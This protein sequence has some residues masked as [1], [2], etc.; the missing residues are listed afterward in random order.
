[1]SERRNE[2]KIEQVRKKKKIRE[3][4]FVEPLTGGFI[5]NTGGIENAEDALE[6]SPFQ[7]EKKGKKG[8]Y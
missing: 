3:Y 6:L 2:S 8:E 7:K 4:S 1:M 5:T